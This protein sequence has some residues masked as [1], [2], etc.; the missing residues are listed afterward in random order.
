M[1]PSDFTAASAVLAPILLGIAV[2]VMQRIIAGWCNP[3]RRNPI[4]SLLAL[5]GWVL[6]V[7]GLF[8][9]LVFVWGLV[10]VF[11]PIF[12]FVLIELFRRHRVS[13]QYALLWLLTIAAERSMPL[14]PAVEAFA[15]ERGGRFGRRAMRLAQL[16][17]AGH[18]LPDALACCGG[19][20]P[21]Y[22]MATI[23][24]G[25]ESGALVPAL[26][27]AAAH[28]NISG[29]QMSALTGKILYLFMLLLFGYGIVLFVMWQ[30][31][32]KYERIFQDFGMRLPAMTQW[33]IFLAASFC[34]NPP[35]VLLFLLFGLTLIFLLVA[36]VL[37]YLGG[38]YL[39]PPGVSRLVR[40]L[41]SANILDGL[42]LVAGQQRPMPEGIAAL[43]REYPKWNVR[44][45]LR[46]A[47]DDVQAGRDW[48][49]S[50]FRRRLIGKCDLAILQ[51]AQRANNLAWALHEL[52]DGNRRRF[53]YRLQAFLQL[54]YPPVI[55]LLGAAVACIVIG[56][57][58]PLIALIQKLA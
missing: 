14:A 12:V 41:D 28:E 47:A 16:L 22:A 43:A 9:P 48:A 10:L 15:R 27:Q 17:R 46:R 44:R 37:R 33:L 11:S 25:D 30:I 8:W 57:F 35:C 1:F 56:M 31:V 5:V 34:N 19:L 38:F 23:R 26:R 52:A 58:I 42:A 24:V 40:R 53:A 32:P 50:L 7:A 29:S 51:S 54:A 21:A 20:V 6:I 4:L 2:L 18:S 45:R 3:L 49:E 13:Q 55:L 39:D 36:V